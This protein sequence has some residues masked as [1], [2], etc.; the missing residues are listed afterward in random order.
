M[1]GHKYTKQ[2]RILKFWQRVKILGLLDCWEWQGGRDGFGYG[3]VQDFDG[4]TERTHRFVWKLTYGSIPTGKHILHKCDNPS[5][6][7]PNHLYVGTHQDN[8]RDRT[9]RG[10]SGRWGRKGVENPQSK[11]NDD[12]VRSIRALLEQGLT[13]REIASK[14][15]VDASAISQINRGVAWKHVAGTSANGGDA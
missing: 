6:C 13:Q 14:Y 5:C 4:K 15:D 9:E 10:R 1:S 7:N 8:M 2:K 12:K 3:K 11:L